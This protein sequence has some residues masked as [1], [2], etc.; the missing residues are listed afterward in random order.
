MVAPADQV[1]PRVPDASLDWVA[2]YKNAWWYVDPEIADLTRSIVTKAAGAAFS[3]TVDAEHATSELWIRHFVGP[4]GSALEVTLDAQGVGR[5]QT[6]EATVYGYRWTRISA[7]TDRAGAHTIHVR[8]D[9]PGLN[10]VSQIG[11]LSTEEIEGGRG[12]GPSRRWRDFLF[13][14]C[15]RILP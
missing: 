13:T 4:E 12:E 9:G 6:H 8:A 1:F 14:P 3:I 11:L 10:A 5:V 15:S 7:P 2:T